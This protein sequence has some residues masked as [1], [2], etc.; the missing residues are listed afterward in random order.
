LAAI[1]LKHFCLQHLIAKDVAIHRDIM[2]SIDGGND[3][4]PPLPEQ[5]MKPEGNLQYMNKGNV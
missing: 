5:N 2:F 1:L 4:L 3:V